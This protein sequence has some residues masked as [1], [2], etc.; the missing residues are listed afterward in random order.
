MS[1]NIFIKC[2]CAG[3]EYE[4]QP[5]MAEWGRI[6]GLVRTQRDLIDLIDTKITEGLSGATDVDLSEYYTKEEVDGIVQSAVMGDIDLTDYAKHGDVESA[7]TDAVEEA[8]QYTDEKF[9]AIPSGTTVDLSGYYTSAQTESAITEAI[10]TSS[11]HTAEVVQQWVT[12]QDYMTRESAES[13]FYT[14][15]QVDEAIENAVTGNTG[16]GGGGESSSAPK[17]YVFNFETVEPN[18]EGAELYEAIRA[19]HLSGGTMP[20]L[21]FVTENT[22]MPPSAINTNYTD[23]GTGGNGAI[24]MGLISWAYPSGSIGVRQA[25]LDSDG[26]ITCD[27]KGWIGEL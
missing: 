16:S 26:R 9:A 18:T 17:T 20:V 2:G 22:Y 8:K 12:D 3:K 24:F 6:R 5:P 14:K 11:A 1:N 23:W 7:V 21:Y 15:M 19:F 10:N 27:V 25:I 4:Q 13:N